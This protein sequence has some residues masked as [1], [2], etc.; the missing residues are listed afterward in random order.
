MFDLY[1]A[2]TEL[3]KTNPGDKFM[4]NV[5]VCIERYM[6]EDLP[7][8]EKNAVYDEPTLDEWNSFIENVAEIIETENGYKIEDSF[9]SDKGNKLS[10]YY[11]FTLPTNKECIVNLRVSD[12]SSALSSIKTNRRNHVKNYIKQ[13]GLKNYKLYGITVNNKT[14]DSYDDALEAIRNLISNID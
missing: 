3:S 6:Y 5:N 13:H 10:T 1:E 14:Y 4:I 8:G 11:Y 12:H 9:V 2:L 7:S